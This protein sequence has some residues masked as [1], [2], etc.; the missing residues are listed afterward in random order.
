V[1]ADRDRINRDLHDHVIER[2]FGIGLTP[3]G[4]RQLPKSPAVVRWTGQV[5]VDRTGT[6]TFTRNR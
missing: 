6:D 1:L 3:H 5:L 2:P 4:T